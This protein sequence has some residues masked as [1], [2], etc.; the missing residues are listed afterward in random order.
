MGP[1]VSWFNYDDTT[2][3]ERYNQARSFLP[4]A[5][6]TWMEAV[7]AHAPVA[8][9]RTI[10]DVGCGTGRFTQPLADHFGAL[11]VGV[12]RAEKMLGEAGCGLT[13]DRV[14]LVRGSA[15]RLPLKDG[16][17]DLVF[18]SQVYHH[19]SDRAGSAREFARVLGPAGRLCV[20]TAT[21]E[22]LP[23]CLYFRFWPEALAL[24]T[25]KLP[26]R[27]D[28]QML[29]GGNGFEPVSRS[30]VRQLWARDLDDYYRRMSLRATSD[31]ARITDEEFERG[32]LRLKEFCEARDGG[33]PVYEE[34]DLFVFQCS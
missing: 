5:L 18:M 33:G 12:D 9:V 20:R 17:V 19:L 3:P 13:S 10:L 30:S 23:S 14:L 34:I 22:I 26:L 31:L 6:A 27:A 15:D 32:R 4:E 2:I 11:V 25:R 8:G 24:A 29:F 21:R 16:S 7:S 1:G 28:V